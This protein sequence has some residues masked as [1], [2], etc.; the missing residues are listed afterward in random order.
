MLLWDVASR[1]PAEGARR[2]RAAAGAQ[3]RLQSRRLACSPAAS[4]TA[5]SCSG[6]RA[7]FEVALQLD[8]IAAARLNAMAFDPKNKNRLSGRRPGRPL[9]LVDRACERRQVNAR[10]GLR[11]DVAGGQERAVT[12]A[13]RTTRWV[14]HLLLWLA[15]VGW[16]LSLGAAGKRHRPGAGTGRPDPRRHLGPSPPTAPTTPRSCAPRASMRSRSPTSRPSRRAR[17]LPTTSCSSPRCRSRRAQVTTLS[18][19]VTRRRQPD[20]DGRP[21]RSS[22]ACSGSRRRAAR[23]PIATCSSTRR[24][25]PGNGI[26]GE[27]IQFHGTRRPVHAERRDL[28]SPR[29]TA[30]RPT[31]TS[32]PAVTL[33][34]RRRRHRPR[35]SPTTWRRRSSTR[36]TATRRGR[37]RSATALRRSA[38]TTSSTARQPATRSRTGS[39][40]TRSRF[41]RPTSSSG[42]SPT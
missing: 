37:R 31:A 29:S 28:R 39:T 3:P 27:T 11:S 2:R 33:R 19:W 13:H 36:A 6:T 42:C 41:R 25:Q 30:A 9:S 14:T 40:S 4:R 23:W 21:I 5:G 38:P 10:A 18:D 22:P 15:F 17:S 32:N 26:V 12:H 34:G 8:R 16:L 35:R 24:A 1:T 7:R 20:R